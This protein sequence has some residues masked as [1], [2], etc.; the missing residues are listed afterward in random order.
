MAG[1]DDLDPAALGA[2]SMLG[3]AD[4]AGD[5]GDEALSYAAPS[6]MR[7]ELRQMYERGAK[8]A[9]DVDTNLTEVTKRQRAAVEAKRSAIQRGREALLGRQ[10]DNIEILLALAKGFGSP[11]K[12]GS[13]AETL[14]N[15]AGEALPA[16]SRLNAARD[17]RDQRLLQYDTE[18]AGVESD[19]SKI[20]Y[21]QLMKRLDAA[22]KMQTDA[23]KIAS[24]EQRDREKIEA[25]KMMANL[26][27][28]LK[29]SG[30][31]LKVIEKPIVL[32]EAEAERLSKMYGMKINPG[33]ALFAMDQRTGRMVP[34][35]NAEGSATGSTSDTVMLEGESAKKFG[36]PDGMYRVKVNKDGDIVNIIGKAPTQEEKKGSPASAPMSPEETQIYAFQR[37]VPVSGIN[38]GQN[39]PPKVREE[40][41]KD[42]GKK[43]NKDIGEAR[44]A[45]IKEKE[46][47]ADYER[48]EQL[49]KKATTS[50]IYEIPGSS[51]LASFSS[52]EISEMRT[53]SNKIAPNMRPIGSGSSS[54]KDVAIFRNSTVGVDKAPNVNLAIIRGRQ[55]A[56]KNM[57]ERLTF[58]EEYSAINGGSLRGANEH[59]E[60]YLKS[61]PIFNH[62][63]KSKVPVINENRMD[64][65][66]FFR[67]E[68][69]SSRARTG[70]MSPAATDAFNQYGK[71]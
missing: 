23:Q 55:I 5:E 14:G 10:P 48:F 35:G 61:N 56:Y 32:D 46:G 53:I 26:V 18:M 31:Q 38:V 1:E 54:D 39:L 37:G 8:L 36:V 43:T 2:L 58:L 7:P 47:L 42:E 51:W 71:R 67:K 28:S 30:S 68:M 19:A 62:N 59:W 15:V 52:D 4:M 49:L 65:R 66:D 25:R 57:A 64:W 21:D 17:A 6:S 20:E 16:V 60:R 13:F 34:L 69:E 40:I 9:G 50:P 33:P 3:S 70:G 45:V 44:E 11:T 29:Q 24:S 63:A 41:L 12:T 22:R 27:A